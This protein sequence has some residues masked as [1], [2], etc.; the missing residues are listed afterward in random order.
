MTVG[1]GPPPKAPKVDTD[2]LLKQ[3]EADKKSRVFLQLA[4]EYRKQDQVDA[5]IGV[6]REGLKHHASSQ[7]AHVALARCLLA[8]GQLAQAQAELEPIFKKSP[9]N[10][11]AG[12]LLAE[13]LEERGEGQRALAIL[14]ALVPFAIDD[15]EVAQRAAALQSKLTLP[16]MGTEGASDTAEFTTSESG[17]T[18]GGQRPAPAPPPRP[19][20]LTEP[21]RPAAPTQPSPPAVAEPPR[22][23]VGESTLTSAAT[24]AMP[25]AAAL[26]GSDP[27]GADEDAVIVVDDEADVLSVDADSTAGEPDLPPMPKPAET[28]SDLLGAPLESAPGPE[29]EF[30]SLT[31]AD[32]Y[33]SQGAHAEAAAIYEKLLARRPQDAQLR[34][35]LERCR[36]RMAGTDVA[37]S[38]IEAAAAPAPSVPRP[39]W[40][41]IRSRGAA[42]PAP[43][44][45][46]PLPAA[47][48][49]ARGP[50]AAA[51]PA[52]PRPASRKR[53]AGANRRTVAELRRWLAAVEAVRQ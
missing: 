30:T 9:D 11:L 22:P 14:K 19:P 47:E 37:A 13:V 27:F 28:P 26:P 38:I 23:A 39:R 24:M 53:P 48:P 34:R 51:V 46:A 18:A 12:K 21:P 25:A 44:A 3:W 5:A 20:A 17:A 42:T 49:P 10:L 6:L 50:A 16:R 7:P 15:P 52:A 45:S 41:P 4:D 36:Q 43:A 31:L 8:K 32:L 2:K 40:E 35:S 29:D 33:E 1:K